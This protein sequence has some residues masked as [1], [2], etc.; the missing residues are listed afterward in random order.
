M[1]IEEC[2][3]CV[4][5]VYMLGKHIHAL[6]LPDILIVI[7]SF[8]GVCICLA[9][10]SKKK[11]HFVCSAF[12][13]PPFYLRSKTV[14]KP[15]LRMGGRWELHR[16]CKGGEANLRLNQNVMDFPFYKTTPKL[17]PDF[18]CRISFFVY[19]CPRYEQYPNIQG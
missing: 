5:V 6:K 14:V 18:L 4:G 11:S 15:F 12:A 2:I 8:W 10:N 9:F 19:F 3:W 7:P 13:L 17:F 16:T 1:C